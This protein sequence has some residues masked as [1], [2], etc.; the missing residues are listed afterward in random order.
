MTNISTIAGGIG[1][2]ENNHIILGCSGSAVA[3]TG[4]ASETILATIPIPAGAMGLN[5]AIR[6]TVYFSMTNNANNKT[7]RVRFGA[8]GAG[9]SG[10]NIHGPTLASVA[11]YRGQAEIHN[12]NSLTSQVTAPAGLGAGG[13]HT[14]TGSNPATAVI[15]TGSASEIAITGQLANTGDTMTLEYYLVEVFRS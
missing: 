14:S 5:G 12:R 11:G 1:P 8:S 13:W 7:P 9:T 2:Y 15:D 3:L 10:S 4:T 6:I